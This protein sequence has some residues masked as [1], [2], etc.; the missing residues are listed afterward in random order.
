M[1]GGRDN[2]Q[3]ERSRTI[4]VPPGINMDIFTAVGMN[5][6]ACGYDKVE[7]KGME[8]IVI[9]P[10]FCS[11]CQHRNSWGY[12]DAPWKALKGQVF[13]FIR[14]AEFTCAQDCRLMRSLDCYCGWKAYW[15][16]AKPNIKYS[17]ALTDQ[18]VCPVK[19]RF[20]SNCIGCPNLI[21]EE[22]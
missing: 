22:E 12:C 3:K 20:P 2:C 17:C 10:L 6:K 11:D 1:N 7:V 16:K 19:D 8:I 4:S 5:S 15:F 18:Q 9:K 21:K 13:D 14:G